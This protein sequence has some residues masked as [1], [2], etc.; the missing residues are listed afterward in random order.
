M[1]TN[2]L[3]QHKPL[4]IISTTA[5]AYVQLPTANQ[6]IGPTSSPSLPSPHTNPPSCSRFVPSIFASESRAVTPVIWAVLLLVMMRWLSEACA[7]S[8]AWQPLVLYDPLSASAVQ[9]HAEVLA[10]SFHTLPLS[11]T[12]VPGRPC[13]GPDDELQQFNVVITTG[14]ETAV[15]GVEQQSVPP[16]GGEANNSIKLGIPV[17]IS[18]WNTR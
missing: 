16:C 7:H 15:N 2:H 5:A 4:Y 18:Q 3:L 1:K 8:A 9:A 12:W 17:L 14:L 13:L 11:L 10:F 6:D